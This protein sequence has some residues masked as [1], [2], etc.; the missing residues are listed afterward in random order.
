MYYNFELE[1]GSVCGSMVEH[2]SSEQK[3][4]G[5]SPSKRTI[6]FDNACRNCW[7]NTATPR[8]PQ[9]FNGSETP[10]ESIHYFL[11]VKDD[12]TN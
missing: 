3:V 7:K 9:S 6:M 1:D 10:Y 8:S 5:S 12:P 2:L 4:E 11:W